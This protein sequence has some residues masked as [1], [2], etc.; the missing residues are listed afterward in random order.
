MSSAGVVAHAPSEDFLAADD[1]IVKDFPITQDF[2]FEGGVKGFCQGVIGTCAHCA[3]GLA[4]TKERVKLF[5]CGARFIGIC[6]SGRG[7]PRP[8]GL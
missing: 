4:Y 2:T 6:R 7:R 1:G 8:F 3:H 5:V